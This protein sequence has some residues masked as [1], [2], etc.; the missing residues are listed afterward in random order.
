[1][2]NPNIGKDKQLQIRMYITL[3]LLGLIYAGFIVGLLSIGASISFV[4][5]FGLVMAAFQ[6]TLSNRLVLISMKAKIVS[7]TDAPDLH[8]M[9][10]KLSES[11]G[12]PKP[13]VA[14]STMAV[15]NAFATGRT[16]KSATVAVTLKLKELLTE[17]ELEA[18]LAHEISHIKSRDVIV[19]T[20]AS[21][22][23]VVAS[24]MMNMFFWMGLFGGFSGRG[25]RNSG[26]NGLIIAYVL[27]IVVWLLSQ[28]LLAALSR[29][30]E[31]AADRGASLI[32]GRPG[33]LAS[34]LTRISNTMA[35]VPKDD[36]R[37]AEGM[38]AFFIFPAIGDSIVNLFS[39]HPKMTSRIERL[40]RL[41]N[42]LRS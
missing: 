10:K 17:R 36:L 5:V 6:F 23:S 20:Y 28:I 2:T 30:R 21:F 35:N 39:T 41:E 33:D 14:I 3:F 1:M 40:V 22:F 37:K 16:T 12:I 8:A 7:E 27:T 19:M 32:T 9:V 24:T 34:A 13:R 25:G 31:Y 15:P 26:G 42:T 4:L 38:N 11:A 29:Y 18:V